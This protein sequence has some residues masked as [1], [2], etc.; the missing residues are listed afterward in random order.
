MFPVSDNFSCSCLDYLNPGRDAHLYIQIRW[1]KSNCERLSELFVEKSRK[2]A[3]P[4]SHLAVL[5]KSWTN[6]RQGLVNLIQYHPHHR[7]TLFCYCRPS[8]VIH[9]QRLTVQYPQVHASTWYLYSVLQLCIVWKSNWISFSLLKSEVQ[10]FV[11]STFHRIGLHDI[12]Y[13]VD[14]YYCFYYR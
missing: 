13:W 9:H 2:V 5:Q 6:H 10:G 4:K 3:L 7:F 14:I 1:S 8:T 11:L 12:G